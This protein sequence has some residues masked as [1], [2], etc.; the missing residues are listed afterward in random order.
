MKKLG[1]VILSSFLFINSTYAGV[2][3]KADYYFKGAI[4]L[5]HIYDNRFSNHEFIGKVKLKD[6]FPLLEVGVGINLPYD[7]RAEIVGDYYFVFNT[8][9]NSTSKLNDKYTV[10]SK[11]KIDSIMVNF[12]KN[13]F[14][15]N[16]ISH[17]I[18]GGIGVSQIKESTTGNIEFDADGS[19]LV[20]EKQ[21]KKFN[22]FAYK[23]STGVEFKIA[24][25]I[26]ADVSYNYFNLGTNRNRNI[27]SISNVGNRNYTI[28]N[29]TFGLRFAI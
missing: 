18:G 8:C 10:N 12:Y 22:R 29:M 4:G 9:E 2:L 19:I 20:L 3:E 17:Y 16:D 23:L 1:Y 26:K 24:S 6:K 11:T 27:G 25:H 21:N 14:A 5:N 7:I 15:Y 13:T 28:H